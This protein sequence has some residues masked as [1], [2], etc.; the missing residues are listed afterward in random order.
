[1]AIKTD[2]TLWTWGVNFGGEFGDDIFYVNTPVKIMDDVIAV[3][4]GSFDSWTWDIGV[5][6]ML[7]T[8][9]DGSLWAWGVN[10]YGQTGSNP[11]TFAFGG[12]ARIMENV[13]L[14]NN[15]QISPPQTKSLVAIFTIGSMEFISHGE[16]LTNDVAP[17]IAD[18]RTMV[19]LRA[20]AYTL[21]ATVELIETTHSVK[22][23]Q[24]DVTLSLAIDVPLP[25]NMGTP[26]IIND[27][28]FVPF[29]Y[30]TEM[31]GAHVEW[32][33]INQAARIYQ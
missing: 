29:R 23:Q 27:R 22:I 31:L 11:E 32:D 5:A 24:G 13:M 25:D 4:V 6:H 18:N 10:L 1:M 30:V 21:G 17:F 33:I 16:I 28:V 12:P 19:P 2:G 7:A 3:S 15:M 20:V 9:T 26:V 8:R 14:P